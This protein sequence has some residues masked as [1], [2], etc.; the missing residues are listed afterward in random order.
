MSVDPLAAAGSADLAALI[1]AEL[2]ALA[3]DAQALRAMLVE[4]AIVTARVLPSNGLTDLIEIAGRRVAASLPPTVR[5]GEVLQAQVTGFEG[6][7]ILLQIIGTGAS[8]SVEGQPS[9]YALGADPALFVA[10]SVVTAPPASGAPPVATPQVPA[11]PAQPAASAPAEPP[12]IPPGSGASLSAVVSR[13]NVAP[14]SG[15]PAPIRADVPL[16]AAVVPPGDPT[17]IETRLATSRAA[18][19][20]PRAA[21]PPTAGPV[22]TTAPAVPSAPNAISR[23]TIPPFVAQ[24][25]VPPPPIAPRA[26]AAP[27]PVETQPVVRTVPPAAASATPVVS[28]RSAAAYAEPVALLRALRLPV[29]P[30]NVAAATMALDKPE[31]LPVA[32]AALERALPR[33]AADPHV[34]TLRALLPFVG[35]ID[36]RSPALAA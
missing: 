35:R 8:A 18:T 15:E 9:P 6:D 14:S 27:H 23:T 4:N 1:D 29:T 20:P 24:R 2:A 30:S 13:A 21:V 11:A 12:P 22:R 5:P 7:R 16:R 34:A 10:S 26:A 36:P 17:S 31:R 25:F 33:V 32:L 3:A 19:T 28:A